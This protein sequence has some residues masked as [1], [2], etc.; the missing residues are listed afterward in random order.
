MNVPQEDLNLWR[1]FFDT[2]RGSCRQ[3][4]R[5]IDAGNTHAARRIVEQTE[6]AARRMA[7]R[8]DRAGADAPAGT[9][10]RTEETPLHLL[11]TP[12]NRRYAEKLRE[13]WEA[14]LAVDRERYGAD[15]GTDGGA[16]MVEMLLADVEQEVH[17]AAGAGRE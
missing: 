13:A 15:I 7:L 14:G 12:A 10:P 9:L 4:M 8:L 16:Q 2:L 3:A 5:D 1:R 17:G 6:D 11:D